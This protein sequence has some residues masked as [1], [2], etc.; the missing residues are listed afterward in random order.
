MLAVAGRGADELLLDACLDVANVESSCFRMKGIGVLEVFGLK[1]SGMPVLGLVRLGCGAGL[2]LSCASCGC[3]VE[4]AAV[5]DVEADAAAL[6]VEDLPLM[7]SPVGAADA[8]TTVG[9]GGRSGEPA[10]APLIDRPPPLT[11]LLAG[12][13]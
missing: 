1:G 13:L 10:A 7:L 5:A 2:A 8:A 12:L 6:S 11:A 4:G 9:F 3:L